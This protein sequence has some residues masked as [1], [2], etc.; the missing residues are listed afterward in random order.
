MHDLKKY[1]I[2]S[3]SISQT[4]QKPSCLVIQAAFQAQLFVCP[5]S[6]TQLSLFEV[7]THFS[8]LYS[9]GT[10][11]TFNDFC[12]VHNLPQSHL[13]PY[14]RAREYAHANFSSF[15]LGSHL[16]YWL[17]FLLWWCLLSLKICF[18]PY[19]IP[20]GCLC[21]MEVKGR[22][23]REQELTVCS[24]LPWKWVFLSL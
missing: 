3:K 9:E 19:I 16:I 22:Q 10:F 1:P 24:V 7:L 15:F 17:L 11:A 13:F 6:Q 5:L 21:V 2:I 8:D 4:R 18:Q 12:A 14:F 20:E 23:G